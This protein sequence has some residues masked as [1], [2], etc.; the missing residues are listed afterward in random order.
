ML[1]GVFVL[2][3]PLLAAVTVP[4]LLIIILASRR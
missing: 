1:A 3:H 4:A 2:N